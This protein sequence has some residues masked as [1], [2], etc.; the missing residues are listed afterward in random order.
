MTRM[1]QRGKDFESPGET[2]F[3]EAR[4]DYLGIASQLIDFARSLWRRIPVRC[5]W[6]SEVEECTSIP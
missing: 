6:M 1:K 3:L 2:R 4:Y 5:K